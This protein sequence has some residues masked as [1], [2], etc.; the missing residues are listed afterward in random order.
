MTRSSEVSGNAMV[1]PSFAARSRSFASIIY[2][3]SKCSI[4]G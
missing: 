4:M 1:F 2:I 3:S